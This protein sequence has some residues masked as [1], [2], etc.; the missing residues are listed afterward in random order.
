MQFWTTSNSSWVQG[1]SGIRTAK[2]PRV[3]VQTRLDN[4]TTL[5]LPG[6]EAYVLAC[7]VAVSALPRFDFQL[8]Q[9]GAI[10]MIKHTE[11]SRPVTL[12]CALLM[13]VAVAAQ[14]NAPVT[15]S[16]ASAASSSTPATST[17][18]ATSADNAFIAVPA[19]QQA[20]IFARPLGTDP[21]QTTPLTPLPKPGEVKSGV[22]FQ[23]GPGLVQGDSEA[24]SQQYEERQQR[25]RAQL[26]DPKQREQVVAERSQQQRLINPEIGRALRLDA[27]G[28]AKLLALLVD[29][30]LANELRPS[31]FRRDSRDL[32][33]TDWLEQ[34]AANYDQRLRDI[35]RIIGAARLDDFL[36]YEKTRMARIRLQGFNSS[37]PEP[38]KLSNEQKDALVP[39]LAEQEQRRFSRPGRGI[40]PFGSGSAVDFSPEAMNRRSQLASIMLTEQMLRSMETANREF[41]ERLPQLLTPEQVSAFMQRETQPIESLRARVEQ[42]RRDAGVGE[43]EDLESDEAAPTLAT[44]LRLELKVRIN[45]T[46]ITK[47]LNSVRGG[48]VSFTGPA[49]LVVEAQPIQ[50]GRDHVLVDLRFYESVR[51]KRRM[52]GQ[53]RASAFITN[54]KEPGA[55]A[56][57]GGSSG[58][59]LVLGRQAYVV[60]SSVSA[61]TYR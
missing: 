21:A 33:S 52:V 32:G 58:K 48:V 12:G 56:G 9:V 49:G 8:L 5:V 61:T 1:I 40:N 41:A 13:S 29:Q 14:T 2:G 4:N 36:E 59:S 19:P 37:L 3:S 24:I 57:I 10:N 46:E 44:N 18:P 17:A 27:A 42:M 23:A 6:R 7:G 31:P 47:T 50:T 54:P 28:E 53:S 38:L 35:T 11:W 39:L 45:D 30:Q 43:N 34:E 15:P 51:G 55:Y 22:F 60:E 16:E 25:L 20:I 26:A